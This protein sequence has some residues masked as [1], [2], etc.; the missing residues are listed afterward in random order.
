MN[1]RILYFI[2]PRSNEE[3]ALKSWKRVRG[4][5][6]F[7]PETPVDITSIDNV[8]EYI[9]DY[10]PDVVAIAGGDGTI[11]AVCRA[12]IKLERKPVV[13]II[14]FGF[15]NALSYCFGVDTV[16]KAMDVLLNSQDEI[17]VDLMKTNIPEYEV[18]VFNIGVGFDA[19]IVHSRMNY[20]YIGVRSYFISAVRSIIAHPEKEIIITIDHNVSLRATAS[21]LVIAN[22]PIIGHNFVVSPDAKLNDGLLDC[23]LFSTKYAYLT[24]LRLRGF[25]HPLYSELGK[26]KFKASH[27]QV[28]GEPHIQVDGDPVIQAGGVTVEVLPDCVKFLKN[29]DSE[30]DS[31]YSPF[32]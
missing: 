14:P 13:T 20:R 22:T 5:Y 6:G 25:N 21:S 7:L 30:I 26:V 29:K 1:R 27:I 15:G 11:N 2:N 17:L 10:D 3:S 23:T 4:K 32:V 19:R 28:D 16:E 24:N 8:E 18:G 9:R 31:L 12:I